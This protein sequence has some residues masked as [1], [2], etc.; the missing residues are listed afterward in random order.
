[1]FD[2]INSVSTLE[3][4]ARW[5]TCKSCPCCMPFHWHDPHRC[6]IA[7]LYAARSRI[8]PIWGDIRPFVYTFETRRRG[9]FHGEKRAYIVLAHAMDDEFLIDRSHAPSTVAVKLQNV[10]SYQFISL[11]PLFTSTFSVS[12][13]MCRSLS[14]ACV[15]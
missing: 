4:R 2:P 14:A 6:T 13:G 1:M 15:K 3:F 7:S 5:I 11:P 8:T 12:A 9:R 10:I